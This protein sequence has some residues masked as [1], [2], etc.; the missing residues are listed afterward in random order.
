MID[1]R[2][3]IHANAKLGKNV[4]VGPFAVIGEGVEIGDDTWIGPHVVIKGP[5]RIG[6]HN[7]I[8][9]FASIGEDPQDKKY[10]G[11]DTSLEIGDHN[12]IRECVTLNRGTVQG[13]GVTSIGNHNLLMAYVHVA[14]DCR[15]SNYSIFANSA[16]LAGHVYVDDYA[17][18]SGFSMVHQ[19]CYIG[20]YS[21]VAAATGIGKDVLPYLMVSGSGREASVFG[22]NSVGLKRN[23]FTD[24]TINQLKRAYKIIFRQNLT[25]P[26]AIDGLKE[27]LSDCPQ[28]QLMIDG[29][30]RSDRGIVR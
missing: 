1:S 6:K 12:V 27:M 13:G 26:Q 4:T 17:I 14:H 24:E 29:L 10:Q 30:T 2:A 7:K 5:T 22:L 9:Q 23:G 21:F 3:V 8:Y 20:Q 18:L 28:I 25:V 16:T 11:E 15:I 19:Y